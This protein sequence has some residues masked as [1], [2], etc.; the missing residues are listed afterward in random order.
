MSEALHEASS[1]ITDSAVTYYY[2]GIIRQKYRELQPVISNIVGYDT[3]VMV[4]ALEKFVKLE[5]TIDERVEKV[6]D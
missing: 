5:T 3:C 2:I 6:S 1:L 4:S